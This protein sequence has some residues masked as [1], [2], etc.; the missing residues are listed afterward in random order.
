METFK[1]WERQIN[2]AEVTELTIPN[3]L[4]HENGKLVIRDYPNLS[5][6]ETSNNISDLGGLKEVEI[7]NCPNLKNLYLNHNGIEKLKGLHNLIELTRLELTGNKLKKIDGLRNL[8]GLENLYCSNN[9]LTHLR[10]ISRLKQLESIYCF[11]NELDSLNLAGLDRLEDLNCAGNI[12]KVKEDDK[13][14]YFKGLRELNIDDCNNLRYLDAA[15]NSLK[16]L[17]FPPFLKLMNLSLRENYDYLIT[18]KKDGYTYGNNN[19]NIVNK[20]IINASKLNFLDIANS[21]IKEVIHEV[22]SP[23]LKRKEKEEAMDEIDEGYYSGGEDAP[24]R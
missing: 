4:H 6:L 19:N 17:N 23:Y 8:K 18:N 13:N 3:H 1:N 21:N 5:K 7:I 22:S 2:K 10:G 14:V 15:E 11:D 16:D 9:Q 24:T 20:L 12:K